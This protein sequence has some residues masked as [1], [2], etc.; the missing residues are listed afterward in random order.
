MQ[1]KHTNEL[2]E[3]IKKIY[4]DNLEPL[5]QIE[6]PK[7]NK[8]HLIGI[9]SSELIKSNLALDPVFLGAFR[10]SDTEEYIV[11][12]AIQIDSNKPSIPRINLNKNKM[13]KGE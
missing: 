9:S 7:F 8:N 12:D 4:Q 6:I 3:Y 5:V 13:N 11:I 1:D 2:N 10:E